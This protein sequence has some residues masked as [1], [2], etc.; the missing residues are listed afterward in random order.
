MRHTLYLE[1]AA[2]QDETIVVEGDEA[3]HALRVKRVAEG[4]R[5]RVINGYGKAIIG[6]VIEA[7]RVLRLA[8][9]ESEDVPPVRPRVEVRTATP[10]GPRLDRMI[11]QLSQTGA[12]SWGPVSCARSVTEART[13]KL[14]R[15]ERIASEASKQCVRAWRLEID[16]LETFDAALETDASLIVADAS[17]ASYEPTGADAIRLLIGPEGGLTD[18]ELA[19]ARAAGAVVCRFGPHTMRIETAAVVAAAIIIERETASRQQGTDQS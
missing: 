14:E 3:R 16:E 9:V 10:K 2:I 5:V 17:G 1:N 15:I 8:V 18:T 12:A 11:D 4:D 6:E 13:T 7:S 19:A